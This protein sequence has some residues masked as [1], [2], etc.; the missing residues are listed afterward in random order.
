MRSRLTHIVLWSLLSFTFFTK[1]QQ[2]YWTDFDNINDSLR[3]H[4]K[5]LMIFIHTDWCKF[6]KQQEQTSF[7]DT[8]LLKALSNQYYCLKLNAESTKDINL[9]NQLFAGS[10]SDYHSLA[11]QVAATKKGKLTLPSTVF[12]DP[13]LKILYL[14]KGLMNKQ[15]LELTV[16]E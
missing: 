10:I 16:Q 3:T 15:Q 14:H 9:L 5:Q 7:T 4:P 13:T 8:T 1:G 2:H 12:L 6:C 11:L